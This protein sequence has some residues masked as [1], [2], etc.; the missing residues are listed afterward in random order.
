[1]GLWKATFTEDERDDEILLIPFLE[2]FEKS[3]SPYL[4]SNRN[5]NR[6]HS[7]TDLLTY[8]VFLNRKYSG[9]GIKSVNQAVLDNILLFVS[10]LR[11]SSCKSKK[12]I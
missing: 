10:Q 5:R 7:K 9:N 6:N 2:G 1:M 3:G 11:G 4:F 8:S 12:F